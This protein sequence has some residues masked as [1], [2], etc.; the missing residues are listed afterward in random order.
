MACETVTSRDKVDEVA[1]FLR[2]KGGVKKQLD[3]V[4]LEEKETGEI[5]NS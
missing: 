3:L 4:Y 1:L 2:A 5:Y